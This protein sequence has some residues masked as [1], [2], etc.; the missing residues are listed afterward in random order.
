MK[1]SSEQNNN[2]NREVNFLSSGGE[3]G[4]RIRSLDWSETKV[5]PIEQ[6]PQSLKTA[7][8]ICLNATMPLSIIWGKELTQFYNDAYIPI[9]VGRHPQILGGTVPLNWPDTWWAIKDYI[10]NNFKGE[11]SYVED[12]LLVTYRNG[13]EE[14]CYYTMSF[15]PIRD[16]KGEVGGIFHAILETSVE[17]I[18]ERHL[19]TTRHL[20]DKLAD[21]K[22]VD[23]IFSLSSEVFAANL[24]DIPFSLF[25]KVTEKKQLQLLSSSGIASEKAANLS[26]FA[27]ESAGQLPIINAI[28]KVIE[29]GSAE[30]LENLED[31]LGYIESEPW[32]VAI[33]RAIIL[34]I[35][36]P[37]KSQPYA[38]LVA[39]LSPR[40]VLNDSYR[41]FFDQLSGQI[42]TSVANVQAFEEERKRAK[43]L[44]EIDKAKTV[45]FSNVSHELRTPLTL[46]LGSIEQLQ[47]SE[48]PASE[49]EETISLLYRN[50]M[51]LLKMVNTLLDFSRI[52]A[53]RLNATYKPVDLAQVTRDL[54]SVFQSAVEKTGL[55]YIIDINDLPERIYVDVNLWERIVFNL[56]SNALKFTF[57]GEIEV[58][59]SYANHHATLSVRDTGAG[60]PA[61][62]IPKLFSRFHRIEG[63]KSRTHEGTGIGLAMVKEL[64]KLHGGNIEAESQ[65]GKGSTFTI[66]IPLGYDHLPAN[67]I[68]AVNDNTPTTLNALP[69][70]EEDLSWLENH[71]GERGVHTEQID[72]NENTPAYKEKVNKELAH[73]LVVDD[74]ADMR[75]YLH[76]MLR[77]QYHIQLASDGYGAL[78]A[79]QERK[80]DL[81][82]SDIMMPNLDGFGLLKA[83]RNDKKTKTIPM[84]FLSARA[85]EEAKVSGLIAGADDYLVKPFSTRELLARVQTQ[86]TMSR[87]REKLYQKELDML[88]EAEYQKENLNRIFQQ[89]PVAIAIFKGNNFTIELA[90]AKMCEIWGRK[91]NKI[92]DRTVLEAIPELKDQGYQ[93]LL[94]QVYHSGLPYSAHELTVEVLR[95]GKL[96]QAFVNLVFHPLRNSANEIEGVIAIVV[97]VN[98][99]VKARQELEEI[100]NELKA[101]NADLDSFVYTASHDLKSPIINVESLFNILLNHFPEEQLTTP[102]TEKIIQMIF[103]SIERFKNT[104]ADLSDIIKVQKE[105][106]IDVRKINIPELVKE[107]NLDLE[108]TIQEAEATIETDFY[109]CTPL[110]FSPKNLRSIV[111]NLISNAIK[112]R[113]PD[114]PLH[115]RISCTTQDDYLIFRVADNGLGMSLKDK[116]SLFTM[117]RRFHSHVDGSGV[118]LYIVK[119][120]VDNAGGKI[121]VESTAGEGSTFTVYFKL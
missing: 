9:A 59:L 42:T 104:I 99:Q 45:F 14:E 106:S 66:Q 108:L 69:N 117:F 85:G 72:T 97:E 113:S 26:N 111:Y 82:L 7:I 60:I 50:S 54:A 92:I 24:L 118:G 33:K 40:L 43:A 8:S 28:S 37:G 78:H 105:A 34:P 16:E 32:A 18:N 2:D 11:P 93:E 39:G 103:S 120:I 17:V 15:S 68:K 5:G 65:E 20:A 49:Q 47:S 27:L 36:L 41:N 83:L 62:E 23:Q 25:Y 94:Q 53:G 30:L 51:R 44:A 35:T 98:E 90:N 110:S 52:E 48:S 80:P 71:D 63:A 12:A 29:S 79:I 61:Q 64:V 67:Q 100:N 13:I 38:I 74:N 112:Y 31:K 121:E 10:Q 56:L 89:A 81:I 73:L 55:Q 76:R 19:K 75:A 86:L 58:S 96:E 101:V 91:H 115:V 77:D 21:A 46:M 87:L 88:E 119:R 4:E 116:Q 102:Q 3:M 95:N 22:T 1:L 84:I 70:L 109:N 6:W 57:E 107:V 114:R